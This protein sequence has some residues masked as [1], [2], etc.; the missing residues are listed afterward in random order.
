MILNVEVQGVKRIILGDSS[1]KRLF[2]FICIM[3]ISNK[4]ACVLP[5]LVL[6][7]TFRF[8]LIVATLFNVFS[9]TLSHTALSS[10]VSMEV[11]L[12]TGPSC[13]LNFIHIPKTGKRRR[14]RRKKKQT[15]RLWIEEEE[16]K[17]S[18]RSFY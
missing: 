6:L 3:N 14:R 9:M 7:Y 18:K 8:S 17:L 10:V 12:K 16:E 4:S 11:G 2:I 15:R 5:K 1:S 13:S